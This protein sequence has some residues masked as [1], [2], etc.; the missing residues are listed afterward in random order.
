MVEVLHP[1][2]PAD[3]VEGKRLPGIS[4]L[5]DRSWISVDEAYAEQV[6]YRRDLLDHKRDLV[7]QD[8]A[9]EAKPA[10]DEVFAEALT[11]MPDHG[12]QLNRTHILCPDGASIDRTEDRPLAVLGKCLQQDVCILIKQGDEHILAAAVL[13]FPAS[14]T[15]SEKIGRPLTRIHVPVPEYDADVARRVQRLFDGVRVGAPLRRN[16]YLR[17]D[18]PD[19]FQPLSEAD[20]LRQEPPSGHEAYLRAERQIIFR[21]P[22]TDAVVFSIHSYVVLA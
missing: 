10:I 14:W 1:S 20:P 2:M 6:A 19:L 7:L 4:P 11:V 3:I 12:F 22:K 16:N 15:L 13:C 21:L 5:E 18:N 8:S 17:Y 9:P